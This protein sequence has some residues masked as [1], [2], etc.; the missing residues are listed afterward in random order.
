MVI[1]PGYTGIHGN[2]NLSITPRLQWLGIDE[3]PVTNTLSGQTTF[4]NNKIGIGALLVQDHLGVANNFE[5]HLSYSYKLTW[6]DKTLS[7]GL[8]T[9]VISVNYDYTNLTFKSDSDPVFQGT[10]L[11]GTQPNFGAGIA[12]MSDLMFVG[13]SAPRMLNT[14]FGDG[15]TSTLRYQRHFYGSFGYLL[16]INSLLKLKPSVL[17]RIVENTPVSYD[18]NALLLLNNAIWAG[19]FTRNL[20][21]IG[22]IFQIDLNNAYRFG[23]NFE[24]PIISGL[25]RFTTHEFML[26]IDLGLWGQQ[27]VFQRYF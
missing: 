27:D 16:D 21:S 5:A 22:L 11:K 14:D 18:I 12:F 24:L 15:V 25:T 3:H 7:F 2:T 23:Y 9:G 1:N 26:S 13:I 17:I 10:G 6:L 8:Q 4:L 20:E 19:A